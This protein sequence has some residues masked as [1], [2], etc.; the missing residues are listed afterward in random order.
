MYICS[1]EDRNS[2]RGNKRLAFPFHHHQF[3]SDS[4]VKPSLKDT[5]IIIV[6]KVAV[7]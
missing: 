2:A 7:L 4:D 3:V 6:H 5:L 1:T